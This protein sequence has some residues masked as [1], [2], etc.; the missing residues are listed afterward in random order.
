MRQNRIVGR[1]RR[2]SNRFR[3]RDDNGNFI[4]VQFGAPW[5]G[6]YGGYGG[7]YGYDGYQGPYGYPFDNPAWW[8][9][10]F[11]HQGGY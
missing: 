8:D 9:M 2:R 6:G 4:P 7:G 1:D 11:H 5:G 3:D 10:R